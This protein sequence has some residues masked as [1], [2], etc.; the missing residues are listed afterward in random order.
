MKK[1]EMLSRD[2]YVVLSYH[3]YIDNIEYTISL[4]KAYL[5]LEVYAFTSPFLS[6]TQ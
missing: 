5:T 2:G 4:C 3:L 1:K 6:I